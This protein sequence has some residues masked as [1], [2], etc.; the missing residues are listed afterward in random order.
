MTSI[1]Q[2]F[3]RKKQ[4]NQKLC[5]LSCSGNAV[6]NGGKFIT[7]CEKEK[8]CRQLKTKPVVSTHYRLLSYYQS[9][10]CVAGTKKTV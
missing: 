3:A 9:D 5:Q 1:T 8:I 7:F 2:S 10:A 4:G 6:E